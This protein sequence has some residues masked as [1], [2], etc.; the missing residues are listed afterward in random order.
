[1]TTEP[2]SGPVQVLIVEDHQVVAEGLSALLDE[3]PGLHVQGWAP[4]VADAT[5]SA[6]QERVDVAVLDFWLPDGSGV[7]AAAGIRQHRPEAAVVFVSADDSDQAMIAAIEAGASGYLIKT[8]SGEEIVEAVLRASA[9]EMLI[10]ASKLHELL[11]RS[12]EA[13]RERS[14]RAQA[15]ASLTTR[16]REILA[17]MSK[18]LDNREISTRLNIAYPTVRSHVRKVLEKLGARSKLEAVVKAAAAEEP[19]GAHLEDESPAD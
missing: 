16:E 12:R 11:T 1:M 8:A 3:H 10:P 19:E 15:L 13:T 18:G 6:E 9:G 4:T 17:M 14:G 5:R 2:D 7:D